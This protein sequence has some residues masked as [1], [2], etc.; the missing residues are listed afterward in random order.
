MRGA[1]VLP[2]G[3][4]DLRARKGGPLQAMARQFGRVNSRRGVS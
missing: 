4:Q 3:R 2:A 1:L